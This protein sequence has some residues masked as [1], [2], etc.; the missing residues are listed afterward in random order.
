MKTRNLV[1]VCLLLLSFASQRLE[2]QIT[3]GIRDLNNDFS[4]SV[5]P[6][7]LIS[8]YVFCTGANRL[9]VV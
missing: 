6:E 7:Q 5:P 8:Y 2:A 4:S 9:V 3:L 1:M